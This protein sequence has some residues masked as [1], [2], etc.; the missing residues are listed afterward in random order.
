VEA[1][2]FGTLPDGRPVRR[3]TLRNGGVE[4]EA[5]EYGAIIR[6]LRTPD[7]HGRLDDVVLGFDTLDEYRG[8]S[9]YFGAVVGRCA[10][11]IAAGRFALD[12]ATCQLAC[13]DGA[14][15]LHGGWRGFDKALWRGTPVDTEG[16]PGVAFEYVSGDGEEGYPGRLDVRVTY[17]LTPGGALRVSCRA[18][19]DRATIVN[20]S[21][22]SYFNLGASTNL[23]ANA[24][25]VLGHV[26]S[27]NASRFTP[28]DDGLIP[29]G[30]LRAV[31]GT[32][33]DFRAPSP[34]GARIAELDE[35]LA[36]AGGYDHNFVLDRDD[37]R[38]LVLAAR[39]LEPTSRRTLE[40]RTTQPGVQFYSGNFLDGSIIGKG[41]RRYGH[42]AGFCLETQHFPDSPNH[43][44][45]PSVILRPDEEY[46][47]RTE[48]HFAV[49]K[50]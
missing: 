17:V 22:H 13:N 9:P 15:H 21:Q 6:S 46:D 1:S 25:D 40:V 18:R 28:V 41:G 30:E 32:P 20:L 49:A 27:L 5:I 10:N 2:R 39:V 33:F 24:S 43:P 31:A 3:F 7:H 11:R 16:A 50:G 23:S 47:E 4:V 45:F 38:S 8:H 44:A 29:T 26:L 14:N 42:R 34:M 12:G 48:F 19:T 35:Q 36:A 37:D